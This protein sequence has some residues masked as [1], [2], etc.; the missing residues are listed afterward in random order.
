MVAAMVELALA[1]D[2][3]HINDLLY[4]SRDAAISGGGNIGIYPITEW[5]ERPRSRRRVRSIGFLSSAIG[6]TI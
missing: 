5:L 1:G 3:E 2:R 6:V 4:F